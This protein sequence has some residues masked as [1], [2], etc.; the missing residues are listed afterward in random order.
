MNRTPA[1][2]GIA[3]LST[4][5]ACISLDKP[6]PVKVCV[7]KQNCRDFASYVAASGGKSANTGGSVGSD[8]GS[9]TGGA[10]AATDGTTPATGGTTPATGGTTPATG[11]TTAATD[12]AT[13]ATGGT[14]PATGG[15]TPA[16]GGT[17]PAT[18]GATP[19]TGAALSPPPTSAIPNPLCT[20]EAKDAACT[21]SA[22]C[23]KDCGPDNQG[24]KTLTCTG[25]KYVEGVCTFSATTNYACYSLTGVALCAAT[26]TASADCAIAQCKPCGGTS[27]TTYFDSSGTNKTGYC[28][29]TNGK[30]SCG[31][32]GAWPCPGKTGC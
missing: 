14:T 9:A 24:N 4:V 1:W 26:P 31:S 18:G 28:V 15:T 23:Y 29:C 22:V 21:G 8:G 6:D 7:E 16:T 5:L 27:G 12:G 32:I 19:A 20:F 17:T 25:T 30:W 11:G 13:P 10:T 2:L 3:A